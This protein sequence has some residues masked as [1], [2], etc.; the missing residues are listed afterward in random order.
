MNMAEMKEKIKLDKA[1][2]IKN[3]FFSEKKCNGFYLVIAETNT[4]VEKGYSI[5]VFQVFGRPSEPPIITP[6]WPK[7]K[8]SH[9]S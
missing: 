2:L 6:E 4:N 9:R 3:L 5:M 8:I 7:R 1:P